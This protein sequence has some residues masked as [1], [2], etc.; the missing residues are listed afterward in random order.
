MKIINKI[1]LYFLFALL[2]ACSG[3]K[4]NSNKPL[5][6][7][8]T[9]QDNGG[10][11]INFYEIIS[12]PNEIS[13]L[14]GDENL[15]HKIKSDDIKTSNFILLNLGEKNYGGFTITVERVEETPE[16]IIVYTKEIKPQGMST[17]V[18]SYPYTVVKI[19]SKKPIIIK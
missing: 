13:M 3:V 5:Y 17:D 11:N 14:I 19:N 8:L 16:N 7:I 15:K 2:V 6:E 9:I 10:A 18:I 12:E 4:N 1:S